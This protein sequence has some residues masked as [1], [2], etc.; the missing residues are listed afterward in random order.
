MALLAMV[1]FDS[2][3]ALNPVLIIGSIFRTFSPYC[4]MILIFCGGALLFIKI[5]FRFHS[6]RLLPAVPFISRALQLYLMFVAAGLLGRFYRKY[7]EKL[8]WEV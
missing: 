3:N 7:Q 1:L 2:F 5:G 4:G 8:N 6:F